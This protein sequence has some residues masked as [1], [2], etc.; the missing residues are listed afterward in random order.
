LKSLLEINLSEWVYTTHFLY[1]ILVNYDTFISL[2]LKKD[3]TVVEYGKH[4]FTVGIVW[5][6]IALQTF[7][8]GF[9]LAVLSHY[10]I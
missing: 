4:T 7:V 2:S 1:L 10:V 3:I 8:S 9:F 5:P 6:L